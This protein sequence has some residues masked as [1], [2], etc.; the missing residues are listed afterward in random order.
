MSPAGGNTKATFAGIEGSSAFFQVQYNPREFS[1]TKNVTWQEAETQGQ[2]ANPIQYQKGAPMTAQM[3]LI[4]DTTADDPPG[5]VQ[6]VWV[7]QLLSLTNASEQAVGGE[8]AQLGK[9][10]PPALVFTWGT[11]S[12]K[13]VIESVNV[14]YLMFATTGEAV[15][16]KCTVRLKE[17]ITED[18]AGS[19]SSGTF[20]NDKIDLV[21]GGGS[22]GSTRVVPVS[23][24]QT[25]SQIAASY[26][27]DVRQVCEMNGIDDPLGDYTGM[28]L[29][30]P[31]SRF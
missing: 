9:K 22:S 23:G 15:R 31:L 6:K 16:A 4:F 10:R 13:C 2:S 27:A 20:G 3:E 1:V 14:S 5:N 18:F 11:F 28:A 26:G 21:S 30:I 19:G 8:Q 7:D 12:M 25:V 24:G 29:A 17:W